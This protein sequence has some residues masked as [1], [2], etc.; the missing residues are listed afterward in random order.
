[1]AYSKERANRVEKKDVKYIPVGINENVKLKSARTETSPNGNVFLEITFEKD[2]ATLTQT[3]WKPTLGGFVTTEEQLQDREDRQFS[4][5]L[6]ILHCYYA[7]ELLNFTGSSFEEFA[8]WVTLLLN[9]ADKNKLLRVKVVYNNKG[10][11]TLPGYSKYTF[12]EPME[13]PEGKSSAIAI[14]GIDN[15]QKPI[16]ADVETPVDPLS[17]VEQV[18]PVMQGIANDPASD[19]PF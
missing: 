17:T 12:I 8:Q 5:M 15:M 16:T 3:E 9:S 13:L 2:G 6:Q 11:T 1:M 10:Y 19:L 7:D 14:L 18:A 4:R